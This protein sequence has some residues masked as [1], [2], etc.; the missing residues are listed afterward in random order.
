MERPD[1]DT[2]PWVGV[3]IG[4][5][6]AAA[7]T[8][9]AFEVSNALDEQSLDVNVNGNRATLSKAFREAQG[10]VVTN[11]IASTVLL[12]AAVSALVLSVPELLD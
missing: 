7:G 8:V 4:V 10:R 9:F 6:L 2:M 3:G 12:S 5:A 1:D 11:T